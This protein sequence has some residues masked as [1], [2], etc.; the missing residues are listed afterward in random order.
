M[1]PLIASAIYCKENYVASNATVTRID[2]KR[3][4]NKFVKKVAI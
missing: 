1:S 4:K 2:C 3:T